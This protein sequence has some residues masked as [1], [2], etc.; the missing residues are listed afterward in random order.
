MGHLHRLEQ[1]NNESFEGGA[2]WLCGCAMRI[3]EAE[4][5]MRHASTL[6]WQNGFMWYRV[7]GDS[8]IGK[9]AHRFG[10]GWY[11]PA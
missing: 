3:D 4:Y 9:Q 1:L 8:Y 6:R 11:F 2:S 5:A 7:D 10:K